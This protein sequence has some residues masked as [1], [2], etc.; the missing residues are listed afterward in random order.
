MA[1]I[2]ATGDEAMPPRQTPAQAAPAARRI[3]ALDFVRGVALCGILLMNIIDFGLPDA[4]TN[5][6]NSGG[7]TGVNLVT[8]VITEIGFEGTQRALFSML[9]GASVILFTSRLEA[10]G[11]ADAA[12]IYV[13]RNLW[14]VGF[15]MV[16]AFLLLW[17]GDILYSYGIVALFLYAFRKL[18][19]KWM[20][21]LGVGALL[22]GA[23]WNYNETRA[24]LA[25]Y[26]PYPAAAAARDAGAELTEAQET[27]ISEWEQ[28]Q[29]EYISSADAIARKIRNYTTNYEHAFAYMAGINVIYQTY[30]LYRY[31][32]DIFG[33]MLIGMALF[34][35][36]V[37]TLE[38]RTG[39]YVAMMLGGYAI[40]LATNA[41]ETKY[42]MDHG[43]S[44]LAF[45]EV[46]TTYDLGRLGMTI[47][48][49]GL[50]LLFV[51][52]GW[53]RW[54]R[55]GFAAVGRMAITNYLMHSAICLVI[56][57]LMGNYGQLERHQ[58]YYVVFAIW[59]FQLVFSSVWLKLYKF[60]PVEWLWR[61]L[62]YLKPQP[63]RRRK[64]AGG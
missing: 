58:L 28:E 42:I 16:N 30:G 6:Q 14:L 31:F 23:V 5:P 1:T 19:A 44:A 27:A 60:G 35:L 33:M 7:A 63:M 22:A 47:G 61:S 18:A 34:R 62:T 55:R 26:E 3:E 11:R 17:H 46:S 29:S 38:R 45:A 64:E 9:F 10:Q 36:G 56:F 51:R 20:L 13:R 50:L 24:T 43:F 52:S 2:A 37:L 32:F 40:G 59:A 57:I 53:L 39:L 21:L 12:D 54:L 4:Y 49:L 48:H 25:L 8:W 41:L 15:G